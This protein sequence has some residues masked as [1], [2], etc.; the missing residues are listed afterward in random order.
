MRLGTRGGRA[1]CSC[2]KFGEFWYSDVEVTG[3]QLR[4]LV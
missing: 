3:I 2:V 4:G 1:E